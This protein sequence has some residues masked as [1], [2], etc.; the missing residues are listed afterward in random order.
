MLLVYH[1]QPEVLELN[2]F[3]EQAVRAYDDV[4]LALL[5]AGDYLLLLLCR[6]EPAQGRHLH[7]K[8]RKP[9]AEGG[10]V[11]LGEHGGRHEDG[12]LLSVE[13]SLEGG[14][15]GDLGFAVAHIPADKPVHGFG[16]AHVG[17]RLLYGARLVGRLLVLEAG[18]ELGK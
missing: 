18:L 8:G 17:E 3:S 15:H 1:Y 14:A 2:V 5:E 9:P 13:H 6:A 4:N 12:D 11:L 16:L 10:V 7:G